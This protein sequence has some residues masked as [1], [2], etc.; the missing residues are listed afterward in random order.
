MIKI[1]VSKTLQEKIRNGYPWIFHYQIKNLSGEP[2]E[3]GVIYDSRNRFLAIGLYD[4]FSDIR[5]RI[6]QTSQ[7]VEINADFFKE[8]LLKALKLRKPLLDSDIT[9]YRV[10]HGENDGFPG[11]VLD[12]YEDTAVVKLYT[13]AW[14]PYLEILLSLMME[15]LSIRRCVL[16]LSRNIRKLAGEKFRIEDGQ[17]LTGSEI[18]DPVRFRENG[19]VFEAD[20]TR[21][22]KT[23]FFLDQRENREHIRTFSKD[24]SVL[25]VFS[26]NGA[27][28]AYAFSG[29][30]RSVLEMDTNPFALKISGKI[31]KLNFPGGHFGPPHLLQIQGDAFEELGKLDQQ[32]KTFSLVI[33]DPP[34]FASRKKQK[35]K[36]LETYRKLAAVGS[37]LTEPNGILFSASCSAHVG[38]EDF[39][40]AVFSGIRSTGKTGQEILR[41]GHALDH[42]VGFKEGAYLK[43][44]YCRIAS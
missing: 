8:R 22:H 36:A 17:I 9:G 16:R 6:L 20:I 4:P 11:L 31:L 26:Y 24:T 44:L 42:P 40:A 39:Y 10:V 3:L 23:G 41:T 38:A 33:L 2:G 28:S 27:F 37:R 13:V 18:E 25:N 7:S 35:P 5:L 15:L 21:G 30:A 1:Q 19:L 43:G 32:N 29:G 34:A 12:R 14:A